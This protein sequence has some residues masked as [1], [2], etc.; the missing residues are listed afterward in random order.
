MC[1]FAFDSLESQFDNDKLLDHVVWYPARIVERENTIK[2]G[3]NIKAAKR[4]HR[5]E[6]S[7]WGD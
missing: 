6:L 1:S 4:E 5:I 2:Y 3:G 7:E